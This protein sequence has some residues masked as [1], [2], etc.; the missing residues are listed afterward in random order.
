M[1][2]GGESPSLD[3]TSIG[4]PSVSYSEFLE[5]LNSDQVAFVEFLAPNG[6][7]AYVTFKGSDNE[8]NAAP[9]RI[10][11]GYPLEVGH[12]L[13]WDHALFLFNISRVFFCLLFSS[14]TSQFIFSL[15]CWFVF[16]LND[17]TL[18]DGAALLL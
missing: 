9:I 4:E 18:R 3:S 16:D 13:R 8:K 6:D 10:G 14:H 7:A 2:I 17:R 5:R 15:T 11:E 12:W 1:S